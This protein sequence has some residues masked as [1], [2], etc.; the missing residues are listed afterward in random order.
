MVRL[1]RIELLIDN[2]EV[3][4]VHGLSGFIECLYGLS[5]PSKLTILQLTETVYSLHLLPNLIN[6]AL[7]ALTYSF[8]VLEC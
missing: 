5:N 3:Y 8:G 1:I 7:D 4:C 6:N 2:L